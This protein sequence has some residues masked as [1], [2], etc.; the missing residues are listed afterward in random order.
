MN[1]KTINTLSNPQKTSLG[2]AVE[3]EAF[4]Y[5]FEKVIEER[6]D[7]FEQELEDEGF[8][9]IDREY[10]PLAPSIFNFKIICTKQKDL[11]V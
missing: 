6:C 5:F 2:I 10:I 8:T 9:I 7:Q 1:I 3:L 11:D 4:E